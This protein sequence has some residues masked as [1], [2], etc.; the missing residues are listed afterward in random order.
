MNLFSLNALIVLFAKF[1]YFLLFPI[2]VIEGPIITVIAGYLSQQKILN[3]FIAY[4]V[5]IISDLVGDALY[6]TM[7]RWGRNGLIDK[8]GKYIGLSRERISSLD[9]H[10]EKHSGKTI[11]LSKLAHGVGAIIL[12]AAGASGMPFGKF[13]FYNF[14]GSIPKSLALMIV[15]YFFGH[16]YNKINE[17]FDSAGL[18][19]LGIT[20]LAII[21][22]FI[23]RS[24]K[25][26]LEKKF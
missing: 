10:F 11:L 15:G 2:V 13:I 3:F 23:N 4:I 24:L 1:K 6:Y 25:K 14:V 12:V 21:I 19:I 5:V 20:I 17:Y 26:K 8:W 18:A 22:Y 9:I 7:G 16:A